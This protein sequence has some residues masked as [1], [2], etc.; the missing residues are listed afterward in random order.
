MLGTIA[1]PQGQKSIAVRGKDG[2]RGTRAGQY[3]KTFSGI[4]GFAHGEF[5]ITTEDV[6]KS[7]IGP[8]DHDA[9]GVYRG[10]AGHIKKG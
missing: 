1:A 2:M 9:Q 8:T 6:M 7:A 10:H 4:S 5:R 3:G